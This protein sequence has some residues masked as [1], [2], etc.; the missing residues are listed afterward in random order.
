MADGELNST[1]IGAVII[2]FTLWR[3]FIYLHAGGTQPQFDGDTTLVDTEDLV[4]GTIPD[5][6]FVLNALIV[7]ISA[8]LFV[9]AFLP[10]FAALAQTIIAHPIGAII[11]SVLVGLFALGV[12]LFADYF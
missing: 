11:G 9:I 3:M 12:E 1:L 7:I 10:L 8:V 6:P 2:G 4:L 5:G